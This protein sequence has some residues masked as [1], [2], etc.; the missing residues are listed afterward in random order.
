MPDLIDGHS[1]LGAQTGG[2]L[3][4]EAALLNGRCEI[5][6][7]CANAI[8]G[9]RPDESWAVG[10]IVSLIRSPATLILSS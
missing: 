8:P 10:H 3:A 7:P 2:L 6:V 9:R 4:T 5:L 1:H